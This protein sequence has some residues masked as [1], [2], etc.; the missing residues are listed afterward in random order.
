MVIDK[1]EVYPYSA[2]PYPK[3]EGHWLPNAEVAEAW[4]QMLT[5]RTVPARFVDWREYH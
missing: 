1:T 5:D 3:T 4:L 2:F